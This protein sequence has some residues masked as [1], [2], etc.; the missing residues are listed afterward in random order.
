[1]TMNIWHDI[2]PK[3][4]SPDDFI[5]VIEIP[6][7]CKV[8]YELDKETGLLK[9]DRILYTATHYPPTTALFP[10]PTQQ[11]TTR[12]MYWFYAPKTLCR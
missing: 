9:M 2:D 5:A 3:R 1:M 8:K 4:I 10:V 12:W 11:I 6:K 7:G